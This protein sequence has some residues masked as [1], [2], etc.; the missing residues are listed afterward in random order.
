MLSKIPPSPPLK[1]GGWGDLNR[2][3]AKGEK[4][5]AVKLRATRRKISKEL[6]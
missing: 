6:L 2:L 5:V 4:V 3:K 1:K